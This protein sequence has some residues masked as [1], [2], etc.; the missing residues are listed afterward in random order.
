MNTKGLVELI[1][2]NIGKDRKVLNDETFA[3][4]VSWRSS[5][6]SLPS[7]SSP[8]STRPARRAASG[9]KHHR[10]VQ[11]CNEDADGAE[12]RVLACFHG[13]RNIPAIINLVE[14]RKLS[15]SVIWL[16]G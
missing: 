14:K 9:R 7:P 11:R 5:P 1:V 2:L 4:L 13:S 16:D 15:A 3:I 6:P 10:T 12:L 8:Q